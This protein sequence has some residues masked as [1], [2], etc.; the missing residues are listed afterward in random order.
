MRDPRLLTSDALGRIELGLAS[1]R[2]TIERGV[3]FRPRL[4]DI[5]RASKSGA[6]V[7]VYATQLINHIAVLKEA[8][9]TEQIS[10]WLESGRSR[11]VVESTETAQAIATAIRQGVWK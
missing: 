9:E 6:L 3:R 5:E 4:T 1:H 8:S 11:T 7:L 2:P 10:V